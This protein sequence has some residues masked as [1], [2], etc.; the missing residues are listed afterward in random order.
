MYEYKPK[1]CTWVPSTVRKFPSS[2]VLECKYL[3][4]QRPD[5]I[6]FQ[7]GTNY[8]GLKVNFKPSDCQLLTAAYTNTL[9]CD[10]GK[11]NLDLYIK[12]KKTTQG[13]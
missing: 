13:A 5:C 4:D 6:S 7:F 10:G 12:T 11:Y 2:T 1:V 3:C 9:G 8:G